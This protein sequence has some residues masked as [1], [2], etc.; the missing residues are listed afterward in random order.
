VG[1]RICLRKIQHS[2]TT[3]AANTEAVET[4]NNDVFFS[5]MEPLIAILFIVLAISCLVGFILHCVFLSRLRT[6]HPQTWEALERPALF[7]NNSIGNGVAV[8]RFLWQRKYRELGDEQF[9]RFADFLRLY[10][11]AYTVLF[12]L[13]MLVFIANIVMHGNWGRMTK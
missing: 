2:P 7:L 5:K 1:C 3:R 11:A 8:Q 10:Y 4:A 6:R 13:M 9:V 12:V